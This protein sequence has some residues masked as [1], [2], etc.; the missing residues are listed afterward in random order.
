MDRITRRFLVYRTEGGEYRPDEEC[1]AGFIWD[2][3]C[4]AR[5]ER[6]LRNT[7]RQAEPGY[8]L[9]CPVHTR[10]AIAEGLAPPEEPEDWGDHVAN[11]PGN[12]R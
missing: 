2:T 9:L 5:A 12:W 4:E 7:Q 8:V 10:Q 1:E 3:R 6:L 11:V